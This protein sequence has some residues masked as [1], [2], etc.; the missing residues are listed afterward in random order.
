MRLS[1]LALIVSFGVAVAA[2]DSGSKTQAQAKPE[3][4]AIDIVKTQREALNKA[5]TV[6]A[7]VGAA[8]ADRDKVMEGSQG[9]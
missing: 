8:A 5:K 6:A 7:T 9:K 3:E 4:K 2:C 1:A